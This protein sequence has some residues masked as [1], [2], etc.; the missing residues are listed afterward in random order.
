MLS[1]VGTESKKRKTKNLMNRS[2]LVTPV[3][4]QCV[5][6]TRLSW[7][8]MLENNDIYWKNTETRVRSYAL[9]FFFLV[10]I[11]VIFPYMRLEKCF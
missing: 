6:W 1:R 8:V 7:L 11:T 5:A 10:D 2:Y 4:G 9:R 3:N